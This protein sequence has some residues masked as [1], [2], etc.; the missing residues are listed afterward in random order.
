M[1][2]ILKPPTARA[3]VVAEKVVE[4]VAR[5]G[6]RKIKVQFERGEIRAVERERLFSEADRHR[7]ISEAELAAL[8]WQGAGPDPATDTADM[9]EVR[10]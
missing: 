10:T 5:T 7:R 1:R 4:L 8:P 3:H 9:L 6:R 2:A